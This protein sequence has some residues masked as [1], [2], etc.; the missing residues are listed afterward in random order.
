MTAVG[1]QILPP[2]LGFVVTVFCLLVLFL[3]FLVSV[4]LTVSVAYF[5][6]S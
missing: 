1:N 3:V 2:L 6:T 4:I 5:V